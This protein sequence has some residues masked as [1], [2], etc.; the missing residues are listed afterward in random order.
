VAR[1]RCPDW[2]IGKPSFQYNRS[3][4]LSY[5][6]GTEAQLFVDSRCY[7]MLL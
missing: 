6:R 7:I 3:Q 2:L 4:R 5:K 1:M